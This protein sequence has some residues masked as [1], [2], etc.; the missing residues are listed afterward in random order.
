ML[1]VY[2]C[3]GISQIRKSAR[4]SI[5]HVPYKPSSDNDSCVSGPI[6]KSTDWH[7]I[8]LKSAVFGSALIKNGQLIEHFIPFISFNLLK[9][10]RQLTFEKSRLL[11]VQSCKLEIHM[12]SK[13]LVP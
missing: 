6:H 7:L 12:V 10:K 13:V 2:T 3:Y 9:W 8:K 5:L 4:N 11:L 1:V